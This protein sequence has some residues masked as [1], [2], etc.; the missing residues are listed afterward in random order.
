MESQNDILNEL[1]TLS[2]TLVALQKINVYQ[3]PNGY[4]DILSA[5]I[6]STLKI[7][8][9]DF[10]THQTITDVP[11]GYF[12]TL[13]DTILNKIKLQE[14]DDANTEIKT[15][16]PMLHSLQKQQVYSVPIG[17]FDNLTND[18]LTKV[19]PQQT[20]VV[21]ITATR[22][23]IMKYAVAAVFTGII[24]FG[25]F[26]FTAPN[27][28]LDI[29]TKNGLVIAEKNSFD[30]ELAKISDD[31]IA[32]YL[33]TNTED[34]DAA[35]VAS[36]TDDDATLPTQEDYLTDEKALDNYLDNIN[37]NDLKN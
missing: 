22:F 16:S 30:T 21:A 24:A 29:A 7:E 33:E 37:L 3:V 23:R 8:E 19:Q 11:H 35:L 6:L 1:Q 10:V 31:D 9:N 34:F 4:F 13:A 36:T 12:D 5:D 15:I 14:T 2:P 17:Y 25:A 32:K 18:I 26:K 20:K 28:T 27:T